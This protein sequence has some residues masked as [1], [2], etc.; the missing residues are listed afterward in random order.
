MKKKKKTTNSKKSTQDKKNKKLEKTEMT[1][2]VEQP[3]EIELLGEEIDTAELEKIRKN[4][5]VA[6]PEEIKELVEYKEEIVKYDE[7]EEMVKYEEK[8]LAKLHKQTKAKSYLPTIFL[9][10]IIGLLKNKYFE[11]PANI[12][13]ID[14]MVNSRNYYQLLQPFYTN[15]LAEHF[16]FQETEPK[17]NNIP[18]SRLKDR[19]FIYDNEL[20][21]FCC[22]KDFCKM[23][24]MCDKYSLPDFKDIKNSVILFLNK[25]SEIATAKFLKKYI[26]DFVHDKLSPNGGYYPFEYKD[27][28]MQ[29]LIVNLHKIYSKTKKI[30]ISYDMSLLNDK[31]I[32]LPEIL[33]LYSMKKYIS[34]DEVSINPKDLYFKIS[35]LNVPETKYTS[36]NII[37]YKGLSLNVKTGKIEYNG[38]EIK[39]VF[40]YRNTERFYIFEILMRNPG[41]LIYIDELKDIIASRRQR[42]KHLTLEET[43][44]TTIDRLKRDLRMTK[45]NQQTKLTISLTKEY[46]NNIAIK[47]H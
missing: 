46:E 34:I 31:Q 42:R 17:Y 22:D 13:T 2:S 41:R 20:Q 24:D 40:K 29:K 26:S 1:T 33:L 18:E 23:S 16:V 12:A 37:E 21:G 8:E 36:Q 30:K 5:P 6:L 25:E 28:K 27:E 11:Y 39:D 45:P 3:K 19:M 15:G 47:L 43:L 38:K 35:I 32:R 7:E 4:L 44:K 10:F 14:E 9:H